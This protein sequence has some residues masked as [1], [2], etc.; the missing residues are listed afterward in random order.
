MART[1]PYDGHFRI[2]HNEMPG[3]DTIGARIDDCLTPKGTFDKLYSAIDAVL[4]PED[5]FEIAYTRSRALV[6]WCRIK[7]QSPEN[8]KKKTATIRR[9]M[10]RVGFKMSPFVSIL[11]SKH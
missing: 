8:L 1:K 5:F 7:N 2:K 3:I 9:A 10:A 6:L 4:D 11:G